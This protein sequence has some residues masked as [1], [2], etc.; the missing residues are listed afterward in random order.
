VNLKNR[1]PRI[2]FGLKREEIIMGWRKLYNEELNNLYNLPNIIRMIKSNNL[3]GRTCSTHGEKR[4]PYRV[5][6]EKPEGKRP[7][8]RHRH[9]RIMLSRE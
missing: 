6:V 4:N 7:L 1:V 9:R 2:I 3:M 8:G 5:L